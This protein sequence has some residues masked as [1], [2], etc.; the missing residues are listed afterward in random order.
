MDGRR[1]GGERVSM[2]SRVDLS[3]GR[4]RE[5]EGLASR[6]LAWACGEGERDTRELTSLSVER[7][8]R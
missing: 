1:E 4:E 3:I 8:T 7:G 2:V 6:L 5:K